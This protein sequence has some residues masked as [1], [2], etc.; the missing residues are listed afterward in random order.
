[1]HDITSHRTRN[2]NQSHSTRLRAV[3]V[4]S[5]AWGF[6]QFYCPEKQVQGLA[7]QD[8][9][10]NKNVQTVSA[11]SASRSL[12]LKLK[13]IRPHMSAGNSPSRRSC[14]HG[15]RIERLAHRDPAKILVFQICL[16]S[17]KHYKHFTRR[18][19]CVHA[20]LERN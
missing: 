16:K 2:R 13:R 11:A 1:M 3:G 15:G 20:Y 19:T 18:P 10:K 12:C 5:L 6:L 9:T 7:F 8:V 14:S 4:E 17:D